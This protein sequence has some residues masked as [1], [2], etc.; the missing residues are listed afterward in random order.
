MDA[1][2]EAIKLIRDIAS[3]GYEI[4][5]ID[6]DILIHSEKMI[7][8]DTRAQAFTTKIAHRSADVYTVLHEDKSGA[9]H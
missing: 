7:E 4:E 5:I 2:S 3:A 9:W 6:N 1:T 8:G